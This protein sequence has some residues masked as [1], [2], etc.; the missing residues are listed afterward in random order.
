MSSA[1]IVSLR[2]RESANATSSGIDGSR[3]WHTINMSMCSASVLTVYGR[4]GVV[5]DGRTYGSEAI[6]RISG[7]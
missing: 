1:A 3:W 4:V 2:M 7:A 5:D 6:R